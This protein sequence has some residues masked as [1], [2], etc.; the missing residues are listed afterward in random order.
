MK[1]KWYVANNYVGGEH[2]YIAMRTRDTSKVQHAGNVETYGNYS[3]DKEEI[4]R[5]VNMLNKEED[6]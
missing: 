2:L 3:K 4:Q 6:K 1:S 5:I